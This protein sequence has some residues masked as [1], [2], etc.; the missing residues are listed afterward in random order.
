MNIN[1]NLD[2]DNS[3]LT[4]FI[5]VV[6]DGSKT[7]E[8]PEIKRV[9]LSLTDHPCFDIYGESVAA[10]DSDFRKLVRWLEAE[11]YS[12]TGWWLMELNGERNGH[13]DTSKFGTDFIESAF[14]QGAS[15]AILFISNWTK[16][17]K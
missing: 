2:K 12:G 11:G 9:C 5:N 8:I 16:K 10:I 6:K 13:A 3:G 7:L 15:L 1:Y 14:N 4:A 17:H